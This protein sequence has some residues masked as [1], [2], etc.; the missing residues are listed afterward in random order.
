MIIIVLIFIGLKQSLK[1]INSTLPSDAECLSMPAY[2]MSDRIIITVA[3]SA[4]DELNTF[5][6]H[7][8]QLFNSTAFNLKVDYMFYPNRSVNYDKFLHNDYRSQYYLDVQYRL[9][10][11][12]Y[13]QLSIL[14]CEQRFINESIVRLLIRN[15]TEGNRSNIFRI[16]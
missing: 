4:A 11:K 6:Y 8:N 1:F 7:S 2:V 5:L 16:F 10:A 9:L 3:Q 14:Q 13:T 15:V 12:N